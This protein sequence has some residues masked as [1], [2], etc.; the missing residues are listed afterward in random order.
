MKYE[1]HSK[2]LEIIERYVV[3]TQE[4]LAE[5]L[6]EGGFD[7]TQAT[8]SR[9]IKELRLTKV[10]TENG[11]YKYASINGNNASTAGKLRTIFSESI[12]H[13]DYAVNIIV[14]KTLAGMA[15][16]A[17]ST[18]DAM[19]LPEILGTIAGDDTFMVILRSEQDAKDLTTKFR[20]MIK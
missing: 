6:K 13:I 11:K 19:N 2:I 5:K 7:V 9:D 12:V 4:E 8:V 16:A 20:K 17:A 18:I 3:E 1:R 15:Q 14:I 10:L